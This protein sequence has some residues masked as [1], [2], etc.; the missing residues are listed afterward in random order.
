MPW[1][2]HV[3]RAMAVLLLS[4]GLSGCAEYGYQLNR[5]YGLDCRPEALQGGY[6]VASNGAKK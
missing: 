3:G 5:L 2:K 6:C 1:V 4:L